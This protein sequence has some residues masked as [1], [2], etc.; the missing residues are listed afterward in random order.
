MSAYKYMSKFW[1]ERNQDFKQLR[2]SRLVRWRREPAVIR[3]ENPTRIDRARSLGYHRK[4]GYIVAR[5]RVPRGGRR[6]SRPKSGRRSKKRQH[7]L[8]P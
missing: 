3:I 5:V 4:K 1:K 7:P 6:K 8:R 2:I